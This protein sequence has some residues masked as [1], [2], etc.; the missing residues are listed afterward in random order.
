MPIAAIARTPPPLWTTLDRQGLFRAERGWLADLGPGIAPQLWIAATPDPRA[1]GAALHVAGPD[2]L[3]GAIACRSDALPFPDD[4]VVGVALLHAL[5]VPGIDY[6]LLRECVR[7]LAP[8]SDLLLFG[9]HPLS[10]WHCVRWT[11]RSRHRRELR[12]RWPARLMWLLRGLGLGAVSVCG[13]APAP[14]RDPIELRDARSGPWSPFYVVRARK[15]VAQFCGPLR[16]ERPAA[17]VVPLWSP[18]ARIR[19][20]DAA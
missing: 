17:R 12:V 10:L 20:G 15:I 3:G 11:T 19:S 16:I 1:A 18:S 4:G 14:A 5:E 6:R 9:V 8:G 2:R 7:V 13:L